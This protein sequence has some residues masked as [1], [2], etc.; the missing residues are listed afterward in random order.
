VLGLTLVEPQTFFVNI[1][2][3]RK[4]AL[5]NVTAVEELT[6]LF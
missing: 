4:G 1:L 2:L 3:R 6:A 5:R